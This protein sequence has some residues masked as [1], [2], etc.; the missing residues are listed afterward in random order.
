MGEGFIVGNRSRTAEH[1]TGRPWLPTSALN[2]ERI[3]PADISTVTDT[4]FE[5]PR[6]PELF[7]PPLVLIREHESLP[8]AYW[9]QSPLTFKAQIVGIH[10]PRRDRDAHEQFFES[11]KRR[12]DRYRFC[13]ALNGSK[14]L[15]DKATA[16]VKSD[17]ESL[18][19]PENESDLDL[20]FW[21]Q[22]L[23]EDTLQYMAPYVRLGQQSELLK[24]SAD[25]NALHE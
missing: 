9:D 12:V 13:V 14:T 16:L 7:E 22:A 11:L 3:D 6:K 23:A 19:Y 8:L 17:I 1:L 10:A 24:K 18:P 25:A 5:A 21:E 2:S 15:V 20:T 4:L